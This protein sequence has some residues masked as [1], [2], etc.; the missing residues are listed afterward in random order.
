[1]SS[2]YHLFLYFDSGIC[3]YKISKGNN[4]LE[5]NMNGI[6]QA[7]YFTSN[8][9][10]KQASDF[11]F[12]LK[13]IASDSALLAYKVF[14]YKGTDL[15]LALIFPNNYGSEDLAQ[16]LMERTLDYVYYALVMHIGFVDLFNSKNPQDVDK[17][18]KMIEVL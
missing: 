14:N 11:K 5:V 18:K 16:Y 13:I 15:L 6:I 10:Y 4:T 2:F 7:L 3:L 8:Y 9:L 1:M 17:L 12:R